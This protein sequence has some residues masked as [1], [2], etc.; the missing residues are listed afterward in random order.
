M[1]YPKYKSKPNSYINSMTP[2]K[3]KLRLLQ[4]GEKG[5]VRAVVALTTKKIRAQSV[6]RTTLSNILN[7]QPPTPA[8]VKTIMTAICKIGIK[9]TGLFNYCTPAEIDEIETYS[10]NGHKSDGD[11]IPGYKP[12]A[13]RVLRQWGIDA[14]ELKCALRYPVRQIKALLFKGPTPGN[15]QMR[16]DIE[17]YLVRKNYPI[18]TGNLWEKM[19]EHMD[20]QRLLDDTIDRFGVTNDRTF[21][22]RIDAENVFEWP[23]FSTFKKRLINEMERQGSVA[24]IGPSGAGKSTFV[25]HIIAKHFSRKNS[26]YRIMRPEGVDVPKYTINHLLEALCHSAGETLKSGSHEERS[27]K[28]REVLTAL[29]PNPIMVIEDA[30]LLDVNVILMFKRIMEW[31]ADDGRPVLGLVLI[32]QKEIE[33]KMGPKVSQFWSRT[34]VIRFPYLVPTAP[35]DR[36]ERK[37]LTM[38]HLTGYI[39][40]RLHEAGLD[41]IRVFDSGCLE[42]AATHL[43]GQTM[44]L[45][46]TVNNWLI[47][48]M[49]QAAKHVTKNPKIDRQIIE[50]VNLTRAI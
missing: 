8:Q 16:T 24:V 10:R 23:A 2:I 25:N 46:L 37:Q 49:N 36:R 26:P 40:F 31:E 18:R 44:D 35:E 19:E 12:V 48:A 3:L 32:A 50:S 41:H 11:K 21:L 9:G 20:G 22:P 13:L 27:R 1:K 30:H 39:K 17:N 34:D 38:K 4:L 14:D 43:A 45:P 47:A 42:L 29:K 33:Q 6:G 7:G 5:S 15:E 28:T